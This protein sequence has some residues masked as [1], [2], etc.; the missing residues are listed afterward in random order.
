LAQI[1]GRDALTIIDKV[2]FDLKI[3]YSTIIKNYSKEM[4]FGTK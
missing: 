1:N 3:L 4:G 2:F